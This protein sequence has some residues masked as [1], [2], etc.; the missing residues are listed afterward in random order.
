MDG[1]FKTKRMFFEYYWG[2][3]EK[4]DNLDPEKNGLIKTIRD[5]ESK[6]GQIEHILIYTAANRAVL[7]PSG[8]FMGRR[9]ERGY[10]IEQIGLVD[11]KP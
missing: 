6:G 7:H 2:L 5:W 9:C 3:D 4:R 11:S 10:S 1:D 8:Q